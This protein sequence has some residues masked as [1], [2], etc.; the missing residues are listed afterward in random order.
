MHARNARQDAFEA[1]V[2]AHRYDDRIALGKYLFQQ[3]MLFY[4]ERDLVE[5]V[6]AIA[7]SARL[8]REYRVRNEGHQL[9]DICDVCGVIGLT[10]EIAKDEH[11]AWRY[12]HVTD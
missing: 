5:D 7:A 1:T 9:P 10:A 11:D 2:Q 8:N 4:T 3:D 6:V 12:A